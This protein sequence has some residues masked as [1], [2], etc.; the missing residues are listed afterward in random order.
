MAVPA[1]ASGISVTLRLQMSA[2]CR[3]AIPNGGV[4]YGAA[5]ELGAS[6]YLSNAWPCSTGLGAVLDPI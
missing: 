5:G 1:S 2:G 3:Q 6:G 4:F